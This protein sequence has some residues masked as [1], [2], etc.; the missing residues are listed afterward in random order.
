MPD[1]GRSAEPGGETRVEELMRVNAELAM[2]I[3]NLRTDRIAEPRSAAMPAARRLGR[4]TEEL[5]GLREERDEL[6]GHRR[7]LESQSQELA[8]HVHDLTHEYGELAAQVNAQAQELALLRGGVAG[9]VRRVWARLARRALPVGDM[10]QQQSGS[11]SRHPEAELKMHLDYVLMHRAMLAGGIFFVQ[12]GAFDGRR[13]DPLFRWVRAY[14]WRGLLVEPQAR[15]FAELVENYRDVEG[16]EFRQVAVGTRNETRPFYTVAEEPGVSR[17]AG[18]I[19]SFDRETLLSHREYVPGLDS[20]IQSEEIECVAINDL[21][22]EVEA[23]RIDLLQ[24]DVEGYDHELIRAVD[25]DRFAPSIVR[26]EHLHLTPAQ[27]DACIE[28]LVAHGYRICLEAHD[29][30]GY[31]PTDLPAGLAE[32]DR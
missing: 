10:P 27:H 26:F 18:M 23:D 29:T 16:L 14:G 6:E 4:L 30:F 5:A 7:G 2:E 31:R 22:A 19:A 8:Q 24:I 17:D 3:R 1:E 28:R 9:V 32:R 21:L 20:L 12:I 25:L 11:L 13:Y 15:F